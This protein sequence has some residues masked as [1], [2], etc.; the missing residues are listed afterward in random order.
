MKK[1]VLARYQ[2]V[3]GCKSN[4]YYGNIEDKTYLCEYHE[5][6]KRESTITKYGADYM[7]VK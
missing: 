3:C 7:R 6:E 2:Y 1:K 4:G 5:R